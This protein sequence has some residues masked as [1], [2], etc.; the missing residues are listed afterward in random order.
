MIEKIVLLVLCHMIGDYVLQSDFIATTKGKNWYHLFVH[1][2]LYVVPFYICFGFVWQLA[3]IFV[4]HLIID[5]LK[6]RYNKINYWQDQVLHYLASL[7]Y[8]I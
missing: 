1:C 7:L 8:L 6:A 2:V 3:T 5:P 4:A